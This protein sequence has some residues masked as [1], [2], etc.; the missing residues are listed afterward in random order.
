MTFFKQ[1]N[2][3]AALKRF[4]KRYIPRELLKY[5]FGGIFTRG[6]AH[7]IFFLAN[8]LS[9]SVIVCVMPLV[10]VVFSVTGLVLQ[11]PFVTDEINA[12][13]DR[14]IPYEHSAALVKQLIFARVDEFKLHKNLAGIVG[15]V[16]LFFAVSG[17]FGSMRTIL[18]QIYRVDAGASILI[19][20]LRDFGLILMVLVYFLLSITILPVLQIVADVAGPADFLRRFDPTFFSGFVLRAVAFLIVFSALFIMY[21][22]VPNERLPQRVVFGSA[23][24]TAVLWEL[25]KDLFGLYIANTVSLKRIYG[26]YML[27]I[28]VVFWIYYSSI[29]FILGAIIGQLYRERHEK[30]LPLPAQIKKKLQEAVDVVK[31]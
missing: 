26:A 21:F 17:L 8:G 24:S 31:K 15:L 22:F 2:I 6:D 7:N 20:K 11:K 19:N 27:G 28:A 30:R 16:G 3:I 9:F 10:L 1:K 23:F 5:Y 13:V 4:S 18:N 29:I 25:A 12:F 14:L